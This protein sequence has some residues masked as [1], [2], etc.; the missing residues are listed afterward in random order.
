M[1]DEKQAV[2]FMRAHSFGILVSTHN[3][4]PLATHLPFFYD[5]ERRLL[6]SHM[7]KAN[8]QWK[9]LDGQMVLAI[10]SGPHA[11]ISPSWYGVAPNVPTWNYL[12]VHAYGKCA[13]IEDPSELTN[14]LSQLV[15]FYE[16]KSSLPLQA[17][18]T[19][20]QNM[21]NAIVGF[22]ITVTEIQAAAKLSQNNSQDVQRRVLSHLSQSGDPGAQGVAHYMRSRLD[23]TPE[24]P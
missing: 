9:S 4:Q 8:P 21:M 6:F 7:A 22:S 23:G 2:E 12:A 18:E 13:L 11:Y 3:S 17:S 20:Y 14:I 5:I 24:S 16:P 19:F 10:F 1:E 15:L